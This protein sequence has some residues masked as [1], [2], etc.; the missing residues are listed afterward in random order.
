MPPAKFDP[1]SNPRT[2][3]V[4]FLL[5]LGVDTPTSLADKLKIK[6]PSVMEQLARLRKI[7]VV[8]LGKK[9]GKEQHYMIDWGGLAEE[10]IHRTLKPRYAPGVIRHKQGTEFVNRFPKFRV[11]LRTYLKHILS[12]LDKGDEHAK[13]L[14]RYEESPTVWQLLDSLHLTLISMMRDDGIFTE[15]LIDEPALQPF[16]D[17]LREWVNKSQPVDP[18]AGAF[19]LETLSDL[20]FKYRGEAAP[21]GRVAW[22]D[23][24]LELQAPKETPRELIA[25]PQEDAGLIATRVEAEALKA[26][27]ITMN[28]KTGRYEVTDR[29]LVFLTEWE[30]ARPKALPAWLRNKWEAELL[31]SRLSAILS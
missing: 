15:Q 12:Q 10:T 6:P 22:T 21:E 23:P 5:V 17:C 9:T 14:I 26:G 16:S 7:H 25:T 2:S 3:Q 8:E 1:L 20:G 11:F 19:L 4:L 13:R 28:E 31:V 18:E 29:G 24:S 27:L 30:E